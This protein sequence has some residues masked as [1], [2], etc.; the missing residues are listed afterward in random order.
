M[1]TYSLNKNVAN[2]YFR[3]T[4]YSLALVSVRHDTRC[5]LVPSRFSFAK[6][7]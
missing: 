3:L 5:L 1:H 2:I 6:K 7:L 4:Q